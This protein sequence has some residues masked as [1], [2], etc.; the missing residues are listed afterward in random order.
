MEDALTQIVAT[1]QGLQRQ[2]LELAEN[3]N[4]P[5]AP[6]ADVPE[7]P[8]Y[9]W[10]RLRLPM[11]TSFPVPC[12]ARIQCMAPEVLARLSMLAGRGQK[13]ATFV[14]NMTAD[15]L[16]LDDE[17][18]SIVYQRLHLYALVADYQ[19]CRR[20]RRPSAP[21]YD[22]HNRSSL[23]KE[24]AGTSRRTAAA[25]AAAPATAETATGTRRPSQELGFSK[26]F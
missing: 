19:R 3:N 24:L 18:K 20:R 5:Q 26:F 9:D 2:H 25:T 7:D 8:A 6:Q 23:G 14:L 13:E 12:T 21:R 11:T 16:T 15:W 10:H 1:L 4:P 17:G 22:T